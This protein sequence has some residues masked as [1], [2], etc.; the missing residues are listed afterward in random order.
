LSTCQQRRF[1]CVHS[2]VRL[3]SCCKDVYFIYACL[4]YSFLVDP[5]GTPP[6]RLYGPSLMVID[7][8]GY[9]F[10]YLSE[11]D[12]YRCEDLFAALLLHRGPNLKRVLLLVDARHGFKIA[13]KEFFRNLVEVAGG[14]SICSNKMFC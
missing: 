13:D 1:S 3:S 2:F 8:P 9:G 10:A 5:E 6:K 4:L 7:M 14:K 11:E 12:L